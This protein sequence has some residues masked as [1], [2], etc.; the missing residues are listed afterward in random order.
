MNQKETD[1]FKRLN[2][3]KG[4]EISKLNSTIKS[5]ESMQ[6]TRRKSYEEKIKKLQDDRLAVLAL[7]NNELQRIVEENTAMNEQLKSK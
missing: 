3:D 2:E 7:K 1:Y 5:N 4:R 6:T